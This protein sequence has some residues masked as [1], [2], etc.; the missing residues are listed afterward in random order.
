[1]SNLNDF[2]FEPFFDTRRAR[3]TEDLIAV[4]GLR[5]RIYCE[6]RGFLPASHY[7]DRLETDRH[8][9]HAVHFAAFDN[10]GVIAAAARLVVTQEQGYLPYQEHCAVF[11]GVSA[12]V[13]ASTAEVSRLVLNRGYRKPPGGG[14]LGSV[15]LEIYRAM[16]RYSVAH[17]IGHWYAAME[18]PL[19]RLLHRYGFHFSAIGP[20]ADYFGPV[21]PY[22][23]DVSVLLGGLERQHPT[24]HG[25]FVGDC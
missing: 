5:Y 11:D 10:H 1:L 17:G 18:R 22:S 6:E 25:W 13:P 23:A 15:V 20:P 8:D 21:A 2:R 7:P 24:L 16:Y 3:S 14:P 12:P 4:F 9:A 19:H